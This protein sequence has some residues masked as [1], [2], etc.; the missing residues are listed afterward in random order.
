MQALT[1]KNIKAGRLSSRIEK[2]RLYRGLR[3]LEGVNNQAQDAVGR[4][5]G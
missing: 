2:R 4:V 1:P 3:D 5:F